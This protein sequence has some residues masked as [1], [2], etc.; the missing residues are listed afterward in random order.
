MRRQIVGVAVAV[1]TM[2]VVAF[3]LPLAV[4]TR[5]LAHQA[6]ASEVESAA[7]TLARD[8]GIEIATGGDVTALVDDGRLPAGMSG[9]IALDGATH[10][11][12]PSDPTLLT[13][14][15]AGTG[16]SRRTP[17]GVAVALPIA[18]TDGSTVAVVAIEGSDDGSRATAIAWGVLGGLSLLLIGLATFVADR[19]ASGLVG[20]VD[21]LAIGAEALSSGD[22]DAQVPATGPPEVRTVA[23]ALNELGSRIRALLRQEREDVADLAHE[24]R[25]P[26]AALRLDVEGTSA[27]QSVMDLS[28][29][30]DEVIREARRPMSEGS[31]VARCDAVEVTA[32]RVR[33]WSALAEDE[34]RRFE[35]TSAA[36]STW[37]GMDAATCTTVIDALLGNVIEH[38]DPPAGARVRILG[39]DRTEILVEDD[40]PGWPDADVLERGR[41]R[42]GGTGL[43]LDIVRRRVE[44]AG[45]QVTT[46]RAASGGAGIRLSFP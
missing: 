38:T 19:L 1:T 12:P 23:N 25:T 33:F 45:G 37:I 44:A 13:D 7:E 6:A 26:L 30:V 28:G 3:A 17:N 40:G 5:N 14:A 41:S 18:G 11:Q 32:D 8:T 29:A 2:V 10:G 22:L 36:S 4:T 35:F 21:D 15:S 27:E 46:H 9:A 24:L 31:G 39:G 16:V 20:S 42:G 43:G 34:G